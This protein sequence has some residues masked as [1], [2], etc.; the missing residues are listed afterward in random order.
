MTAEYELD[1]LRSG[2]ESILV[3]ENQIQRAIVFEVCV[4]RLWRYYV[5]RYFTPI[6][7]LVAVGCTV[8]FMRDTRIHY[9]LKV[10]SISVLSLITFMLFI[11]RGLPRVSYLISVGLYILLCSTLPFVAI[12]Q[13]L[14]V[15]LLEKAWREQ[16][17]AKLDRLFIH[18]FPCANILICAIVTLYCWYNH[19][20]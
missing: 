11:N 14:A 15:H 3:S 1:R 8:F 7:T 19:A 16:A 10:L 2:F 4:N 5:F 12:Y 9:R 17:A 13:S 18:I 6:L 20:R